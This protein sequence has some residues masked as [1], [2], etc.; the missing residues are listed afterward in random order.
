MALPAGLQEPS[1]TSKLRQGNVHTTSGYSVY[2]KNV[3]D[4]PDGGDGGSSGGGGSGNEGSRASWT[5]PR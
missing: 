1:R 3:I 5:T 4:L 2:V